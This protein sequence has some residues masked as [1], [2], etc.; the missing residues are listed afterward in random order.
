[1][2]EKLIRRRAFRTKI[3]LIDWRFG[4]ALDRN[5]FAV[6]M[7]NQLAAADAAIGTNRTRDFRSIGPRAHR[8]RFV[9]HRL[10]T[11]AILAFANLAHEWP[12]RKQINQQGHR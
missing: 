4:I 11:S 2:R 7:K 8:A 3:P 10:E 5:Q 12:L 1:M 9:R 6:L